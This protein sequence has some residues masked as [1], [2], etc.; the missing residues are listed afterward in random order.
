MAKQ[1]GADPGE[2]T[3]PPGRLYWRCRRGTKEL[4]RVLGGYLADE[5]AG[6]SPELQTAF[7]QLLEQQDPD[8]YDWLMGVS[9]AKPLFVRI[10]E[11]LQIRFLNKPA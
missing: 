2:L 6:A 4:D 1:L 11:Q 10:I 3:P 5:Y 9:P 8:I 7:A